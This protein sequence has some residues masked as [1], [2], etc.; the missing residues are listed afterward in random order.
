MHNGARGPREFLDRL[1]KVDA[2]EDSPHHEV[3]DV[4]QAY[5]RPKPV[6]ETSLLLLVRVSD[7]PMLVC[8]ETPQV[9]ERLKLY[10]TKSKSKNYFLRNWLSS[11]SGYLYE[12]DNDKIRVGV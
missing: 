8:L 11:N 2:Q 12:K 5:G 1:N 6:T 4:S 3:F 10:L 7:P 9:A